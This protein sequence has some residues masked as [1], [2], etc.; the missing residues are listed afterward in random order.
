MKES[1]NPKLISLA[2]RFELYNCF[3]FRREQLNLLI[4]V[5]S[6][7]AFLSYVY[8]SLATTG[9]LIFS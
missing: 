8:P 7:I 4:G 6:L 5:N 2:A 9:S 3:P 1:A